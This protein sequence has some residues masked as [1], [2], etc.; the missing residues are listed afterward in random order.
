MKIVSFIF[1]IGFLFF[2]INANGQFTAYNTNQ[3]FTSI[4]VDSN[5]NVWAGTNK[6]GLFYLN[7]SVQPAPAAFSV[8][9][10]T[11]PSRFIDF[12][13]LSL[14]AD[15]F[16][17]VWVGHSGGGGGT[18]VGGG[19]ERIDM[20]AIGSV[21]HYS[22]DRNA[23][24]FS[25]FQRDGLGTLHNAS[26]AVDTNGTVWSA[27]RYHDLTVAPDYIL[28]PGTISYKPTTSAVF[29]SKGTY[30]DFQSGTSP[31]ELPYPAYTC[32][33]PVSATPQSRNCYSIAA[34]KTEV[35]A[36]VA[37]YTSES[38]IAFPA[39]LIRYDLQGN[40]IAPA[41]SFSS[42]GIPPGGIFN[43]I[44]ITP[45]GDAWV[46]VSGTKGFAVRRRGNWIYMNPQSLSCIFPVG[47]II[48]NNAIWGN[49]LGQVFIGTS[50][51]LIVYNGVGPIQNV[52]SYTLYSTD[53]NS[54]VSNDITAGVSENDSIQWIAT[55]AGI[56]SSTLGRNYPASADSADYT[57][58]NIPFINQIEAQ[59]EQDHSG[60]DDYHHYKIETVIC[61]SNG[62][63]GA[64][65]NAQNIYRKLK[66]SVIYTTPIPDDFSYDNL[67]TF[68]LMNITKPELATVVA[69]VN[70]W[71]TNYT[72][73]NPHGGINKIQQVL[74][75]DLKARYY[76]CTLCNQDGQI[77]GISAP[78]DYDSAYR[79]RFI[80]TVASVNPM[81]AISCTQVY[82]LYNS[83]NFFSDRA[84]Y[85]DL[86]TSIFSCDN[87][88]SA[89]YDE[90]RLFA[91][92]R[93]MT[94]TNYTAPGHFLY[95]GKVVRS[96]VEECG[97]VKIVTIG[98]GLSSCGSNTQGK[99]NANG[100]TI[101]GSILFKNIDL[102]LKK[103]FEQ[104]N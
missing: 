11:A 72:I 43:G 46:T 66:D 32:N 88:T 73:G 76:D 87:L 79:Q 95:P 71:Q 78:L 86:L 55:R 33:P 48:N 6:A 21:Q 30:R 84:V 10:G 8:I 100:N 92:D 47:A 62:P 70:A 3:A 90:V 75:P 83:P 63:N 23:R 97:Q 67:S 1:I 44:Y 45:K 102:R 42:I 89:Q 40:F 28:T 74:P 38:G 34:G 26:L 49:K 39:R 58:C 18:A 20:N 17:N 103:A 52:G 16:N 60:R 94:I 65:C 4:T 9:A 99:L 50:K 19:I 35:W 85:R 27:Q 56:M 98:T 80:A 5:G 37:A 15:N 57:S 93:N 41:F 12:S 64:N 69:N 2:S 91:D 13:I 54:L 24:C 53:N 68:L 14:A 31:V 101:L 25:F 7:K 77:P 96:V 29:F 81:A 22:P 36:S 51:G 59:S 61:T 104:S 82:K